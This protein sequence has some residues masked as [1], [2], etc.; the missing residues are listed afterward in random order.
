M[1]RL[2]TNPARIRAPA[3]LLESGLIVNREDELTLSS[4]ETKTHD[5]VRYFC[6]SRLVLLDEALMNAYVLLRPSS[7]P[8]NLESK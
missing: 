8:T 4:S 7:I 5:R 2:R 3:A 1:P 6:S